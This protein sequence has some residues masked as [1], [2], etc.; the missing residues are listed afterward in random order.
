MM[1]IITMIRIIMVIDSEWALLRVIK[2]SAWNL[3]YVCHEGFLST[4]R[5]AHYRYRKWV[6]SG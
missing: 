4:T 2:T 5:S 3:E 1:I 6:L